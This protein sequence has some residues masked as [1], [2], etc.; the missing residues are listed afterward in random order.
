MTTHSLAIKICLFTCR[1]FINVRVDFVPLAKEISLQNIL[2]LYLRVWSPSVR[3]AHLLF[4]D[5]IFSREILRQ[6]LE[7]NDTDVERL[8][9]PFV[10]LDVARGNDHSRLLLGRRRTGTTAKRKLNYRIN[11]EHENTFENKTN[12]LCTYISLNRRVTFVS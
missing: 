7:R 3:G 5:E 6:I 12:T 8:V 1:R 9:Y 11:D 4:V 10:D 2:M